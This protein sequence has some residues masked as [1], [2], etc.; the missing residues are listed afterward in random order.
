MITVQNL[1]SLLCA[2]G[3]RKMG[4]SRSYRASIDRIQDIVFSVPAIASQDE[5][6]KKVIT[7]EALNKE[8]EQEMAK[9]NG[10]RTTIIVNILLPKEAAQ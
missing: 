1:K 5:A 4:F 7:L 2:L 8:D 9:I 10:K 6:M 3:F